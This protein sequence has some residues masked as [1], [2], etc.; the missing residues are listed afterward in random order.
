MSEVTVE[1]LEQHITRLKGAVDLRDAAIKLAGNREFRKLI[2]D[3]FCGTEAA[4]YVQESGDPALTPAQRQDAL[5][6]A[7]A[8]GHFKR[9]LSVTIALGNQAANDVRSSEDQI[10]QL[11]ADGED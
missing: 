11:R 4:R 1:Q 6:I 5:N 2:L 9:F 3:G 10:D 8:S 7:Q